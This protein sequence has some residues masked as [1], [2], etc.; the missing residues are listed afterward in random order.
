[1]INKKFPGLVITTPDKE[2]TI[3]FVE[4][5]ANLQVDLTVARQIVD[6]RLD[7]TGSKAHY[8]IADMSNVRHVTAEAKEFMQSMEGGLKNILAAALIA[9]NP[10]SA[11]IANIFI[12]TPV[13]FPARFF[14]SKQAASAWIM[15]HSK[16]SANRNMRIA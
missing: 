8:L 5:D 13:K 7:F 12:K 11:L 15:E 2:C 10:V 4:F 9:T 16:N 14:S 1:M 6:H 3:V